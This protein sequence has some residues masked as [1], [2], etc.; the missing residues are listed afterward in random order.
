MGQET[1]SRVWE[2]N[3]VLG[4]D[5]CFA[6]VRSRFADDALFDTVSEEAERVRLFKEFIKTVKVRIYC[7][8][9]CVCVACVSTTQSSVQ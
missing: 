9:V 4:F 2:W 7:V 8:C 6:Q 5:F 3:Q 1:W